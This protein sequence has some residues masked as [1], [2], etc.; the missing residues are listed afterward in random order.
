MKE[1]TIRTLIKNFESSIPQ[2]KK[3]YYT[4]KHQQRQYQ[5]LINTL[6]ENEALILCDFSENYECKL[7]TE[8][9]S[10]HFGASKQQIT[11]HTGTFFKTSIF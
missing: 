11:L 5:S 4:W 8:I 7:H 10:M 1:G 9:Q 3:H 6:N 2:F